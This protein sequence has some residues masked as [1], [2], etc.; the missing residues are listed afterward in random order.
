MANLDS[1]Q[2]NL[3]DEILSGFVYPSLASSTILSRAAMMNKPIVQS[4]HDKWEVPAQDKVAIIE[5]HRENTESTN[6]DFI[7]LLFEAEEVGM[8]E[9]VIEVL[10]YAYDERIATSVDQV[11]RSIELQAKEGVPVEMAVY[12][13]LNKT[14]D[15]IEEEIERRKEAEIER[16]RLRD[17]SKITMDNLQKKWEKPQDEPI[18]DLFR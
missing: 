17:E 12:L 18:S 1:L 8:T 5:W 10:T 15:E 9:D 3:D 4:I 14:A 6:K 16:K 13:T 7:Q 2:K 11:Y